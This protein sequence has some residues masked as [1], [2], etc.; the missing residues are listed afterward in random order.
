M[1]AQMLAN[2]PNFGCIS[3]SHTT[4]GA[5]PAARSGGE[6]PGRHATASGVPAGPQYTSQILL[7]SQASKAEVF[8]N[9][10]RKMLPRMMFKSTRFYI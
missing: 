9:G 10:I 2:L 7:P 1:L 3:G 8:G 5:D 4:T 6:G